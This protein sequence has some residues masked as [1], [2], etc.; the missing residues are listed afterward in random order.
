VN[1]HTN[2]NVQIAAPLF[3]HSPEVAAQH[4]LQGVPEDTRRAALAFD[5]AILRDNQE[6][7][8]EK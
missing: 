7:E 3:G 5:R 4:Y 1:R 2:G 6:T 8:V